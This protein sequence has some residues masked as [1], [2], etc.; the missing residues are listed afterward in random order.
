[1]SEID[2]TEAAARAVGDD[3]PALPEGNPDVEDGEEAPDPSSASSGSSDPSIVSRLLDGTVSGPPVGELKSEYELDRSESL[4]LRGIL[5]V[6]GS[7]AMPPLGEISLG[8]ILKFREKQTESD[9]ESGGM[10]L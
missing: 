9:N 1:M 8:S 3:T 5:R 10:N 6:S 2:P 7:E 4:I